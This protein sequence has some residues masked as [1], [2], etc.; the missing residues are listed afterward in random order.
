[1]SWYIR[2]I[3]IL[4]VACS[5]VRADTIVTRDKVSVNG[6]L[7]KMA[8]GEITLVASYDSGE[9]TLTIKK[10]DVAEIEFNST[11]Y[12]SGPPDAGI[13]IGPASKSGTPAKSSP[14]PSDTIVLARGP[15]YKTCKLIGID[16]QHV[17]CK[18]KNND[19]LRELVLRIVLVGTR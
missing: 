6:K 5:M 4:A 15:Q 16:D 18:G 1:M 7:T 13:G 19:Y 8:S 2:G 12:N 14:E 3:A 10:T 11:T 17:Y 9:K